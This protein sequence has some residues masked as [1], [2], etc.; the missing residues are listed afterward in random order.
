M[1][2]EKIIAYLKSVRKIAETRSSKL[3]K[4]GID[5]NMNYWIIAEQIR[6]LL[7]NE[8]MYDDEELLQEA[9][10]YEN[11]KPLSFDD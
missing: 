11:I 4:Y 10:S 6:C 9:M 7:K 1:D 3:T 5:I 2:R 8:K